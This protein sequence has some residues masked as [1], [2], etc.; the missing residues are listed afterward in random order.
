MK[1]SSLL[2]AVIF[3][4]VVLL[5]CMGM[6]GCPWRDNDTYLQSSPVQ[7]VPSTPTVVPSPTPTAIPTLGPIVLYEWLKTTS[8]ER[9][10][11]TSSGNL[12]GLAAANAKCV[13]Y[14]TTGLP[15]AVAFI[16]T[17][18]SNIRDLV[19]GEDA[20][21]RPVVSETG[22]QVSPGWSQLWDG[23]IDVELRDAR[24][25][26]PRPADAQ[27]W[28]GSNA[29]GTWAGVE[30]DCKSWTT[31][32]YR[33]RGVMGYSAAIDARWINILLHPCSI[34]HHVLCIAW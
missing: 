32:D 25:L 20:T 11:E 17:S 5:V 22:V 9:N 34:K 16:S 4:S 29:D 6:N 3:V 12:G 30:F 18:T 13:A 8:P 7:P 1:T 19:T 26:P 28:S 10:A 24:V 15:N 14:N 2:F 33:Y 27:W 23:G 21:M 31:S